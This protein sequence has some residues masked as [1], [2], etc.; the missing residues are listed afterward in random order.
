MIS[1]AQN[2]LVVSAILLT[3][4]LGCLGQQPRP[5]AD[6]SQHL[7][8]VSFPIS[9]SAQVQPKF[10][11]GVALLH[12]F[13][14]DAASA[15]FRK[16]ERQEPGCAIAYWG[17]AM[18][19]YHE[20]WDPPSESD[21]AEG[22]QLVQKAEGAS[23]RTPREQGYIA[24]MA[25]F[26]KPGKQ[27]IE[28]R[29]T[30]YSQA[31]G[32][33]QAAYPTDEEATVFYALSLLAS[34]PSTDTSLSYAREAAAILERVFAEDPDH[35]GAAHY[36]IHACDH[37]RMADRAL[38]AAKRYAMIAPYSPHA[39][40]MPS[41]IFARLGLWQEDIA[42]NLASVAAAERE[43]SGT[44]A[45]LHAMDFLEYA[46][47][48]TGQDEKAREIEKK[49]VAT[50]DRGFSHGMEPY[51][52]YVPAH[53]PALLALETRNW[54]AAELLQP[55]ANAE[56]RFKAM[57]YWAQAIGAAHLGDI[58]AARVAVKN[59]DEALAI[60]KKLHPDVP[61]AP[62]DT[63]KDEAEAWLAFAQK[64]NARAFKLLQSMIQFQD[65]VGKGEVELPAREMYA[66]ML[67]ELNRPAEA[68]EQYRLSL[69]SD[70][71]RFNGLYGAA[72][73]AQLAA[74]PEIAKSYYEQLLRNC[75]GVNGSDRPEL[76]EARRFVLET[77]VAKSS[78]E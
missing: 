21:L 34:E 67:L 35:P 7:D 58:G 15:Q 2:V 29:A 36:L 54:K 6:A 76:L 20:L 31:M 77:K 38:P 69:K 70:P 66:D 16:V 60:S 5:V 23:E 43:H 8:K 57:T 65:D 30:A 37:P 44:E 46:Y 33:L 25:A 24:A 18:A 75:N 51:Y 28:D 48:Q 64:D 1:L 68:L 11:R 71:N 13:E 41:H 52:F 47:L 19:L 3:S 55:T 59:L 62:V 72:R 73:S 9:C 53:F 50:P 45:R 63:N 40:H 39:L 26:Y 49:A 4:A 42:S 10:D 27:S 17:S 61:I 78:M 22:W 12:S 32:K 14:Y 56:P 74:K